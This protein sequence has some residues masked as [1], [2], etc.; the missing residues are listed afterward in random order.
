MVFNRSTLSQLVAQPFK[1]VLAILRPVGAILFIFAYVP[2]RDPIP[3]CKA[4]IDRLVGLR[5]HALMHRPNGI[6]QG[7]ETNNV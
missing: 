4:D 5:G 2:A 7:R 6:N 1:Q 3:Q